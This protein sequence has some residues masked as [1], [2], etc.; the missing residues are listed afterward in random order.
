MELRAR[1]RPLSRRAAWMAAL[2]ALFASAVA[3]AVAPDAFAKKKAPVI[4]SIAPKDVAVGEYLTI[5]GRNFRSGRNKNTVVFKRHGARAIF[6]KAQY[7]TRKML[8]VKVPPTVQ[9]FFALRDGN[10]VPT[11]FRLRV[12]AKKFGKKFTSRRLSPIVSGPRPPAPPA[13]SLASGDC[14][15]DK[16]L[17]KF[18][19]DDDNDL[20]L[21]VVELAIGTDPCRPDTDGDGV[22]DGYEYQ[23]AKDLNDD[24]YQ[25]DPNQVIPYP[26]KR[27]YPNPL[28]KDAELDYDGDSLT[29]AEEQSLWRYT[30]GVNHSAGRTLE[31]LS[32]SDGN[33]HSSYTR[34]NGR[35]VPSLAVAGY[36]R[37][38]EFLGWA[39][40]S[41]YINVLIPPMSPNGPPAG[42]YDI[43]D[44]NLSGGA[45][46][47]GEQEYSD[48][49]GNGKLSDDER[50]EDADGLTNYDETH[51][52]MSPGYWAGCYKSEKPYGIPYA[53]TR[54]DDADSDGDG[55]RDGA[56]DQDHD[57]VPNLMELS[58]F[59]A[60]GEIDWQA[61]SPC[62]VSDAIEFNEVDLNGD[63]KPDAAKLNHPDVWGRVNPFNP[64][65]PA[66]N[67][68]T[69]TSHP[70]ISGAA[71]PF[72][73]S[74]NWLSLQ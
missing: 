18:E 37:H 25:G 20:L 39:S 11:R 5:K 68:R 65:L 56:D 34:V 40:G 29:L 64:C 36:V 71:A 10:P 49:N 14:D 73:D 54:V 58:R 66:T 61:G 30:Y 55:V 16:I 13:E 48:Y 57:D 9:K 47:A 31:P 19:D 50:D 24:E 63:G 17:N 35:R 4:T 1:I 69:C 38:Q 27:P 21:D 6:V 2:V 52:R 60:S 42:Y 51:G 23:S 7:G 53:G 15:G 33:Q 26:G 43:R 22:E 8:R 3:G 72:D 46:D 44:A 45:P 59:A 74:P 67:A 32:Y 62:R 70:S 41:G 12:L 28:Y